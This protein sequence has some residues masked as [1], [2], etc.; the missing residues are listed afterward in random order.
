MVNANLSQSRLAQSRGT[1]RVNNHMYMNY[2]CMNHHM[3]KQTKL[4]V[5]R[6][7]LKTMLILELNPCMFPLLTC[8]NKKLNSIVNLLLLLLC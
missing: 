2:T 1:E 3:L 7:E 4:I 8:E 6:K 5:P